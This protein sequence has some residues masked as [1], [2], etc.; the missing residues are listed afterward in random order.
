M[1]RSHIAVALGATAFALLVIFQ[2]T[3]TLG[4]PELDFWHWT[5][6]EQ[7][8]GIPQTHLFGEKD[9]AE[10]AA[11]DAV[12]AEGSQYLLGVGKADITG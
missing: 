7:G 6:Q 8:N 11:A 3:S 5:V 9:A 10:D 12:T 1:A 2:L 4:I